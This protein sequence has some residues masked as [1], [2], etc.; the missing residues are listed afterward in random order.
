MTQASLLDA[1]E[2][3]YLMLRGTLRD[4]ATRGRRPFCRFFACRRDLSHAASEQPLPEAITTGSEPF[5][6]VGAMAG[7]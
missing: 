6:I 5:L 2:I 4:Q 7:G 1:L 3:V